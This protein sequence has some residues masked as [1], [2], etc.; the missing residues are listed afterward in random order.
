MVKKIFIFVIN[1]FV[2]KGLCKIGLFCFRVGLYIVF[3]WVFSWNVD[4]FV[5]YEW[6]SICVVN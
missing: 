5:I 6:D 4:G 1:W 3:G 2:V